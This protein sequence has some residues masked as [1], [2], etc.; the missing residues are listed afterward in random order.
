MSEKTIKWIIFTTLCSGMPIFVFAFVIAVLVPISGLPAVFLSD[1]GFATAVLCIVHL[2][3]YA[4]ILYLIAW[5]ASK[6]LARLPSI[7]RS[8]FVAAIAAG[9]V[10]LTQ[11]PIYGFCLTGCDQMSLFD[12][13]SQATGAA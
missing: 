6:V 12:F 3:I 7:T 2:A 5:G 11:L 8:L 10:S 13:Y 4:P 1:P 9:L